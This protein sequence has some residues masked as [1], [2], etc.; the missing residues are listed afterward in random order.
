MIEKTFYFLGGLPRSGSTVL[1][2]LL[3]Q[4]PSVYATPTSPMLDLLMQ[5]EEFWREN[6]SVVAN[7]NETQFLNICKAIVNATWKHIP[8]NIIID[9]HR[10]WGKNLAASKFLF[11][12]DIKTIVTVR[13]LP[14]IMASFITLI[15]SFPDSVSMID[16]LLIDSKIPITIESRC[17]II[18]ENYIK[19][20]IESLECAKKYG[21]PLKIIKYDD[22]VYHPEKILDEVRDFLVLPKWS[23]SLQ[24][25]KNITEEDDDRT[26]KIKNLHYIRSNMEKTSIPAI[27]V[28]GSTLVELY[29]SMDIV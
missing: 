23:P 19:D 21:G 1:A 28:L 17:N 3:N 16:Q 11:G 14:S 13:D 22:L 5:N 18:W 29:T 12:K 6:P 24:N 7:K 25:I 4:N 26:W 20:P 8:Q 9:K 2:S 15:D 27:D 10:G